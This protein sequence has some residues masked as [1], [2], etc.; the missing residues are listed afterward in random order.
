MDEEVAGGPEEV[1]VWSGWRKTGWTGH[2]A[3]S[4]HAHSHVSCLSLPSRCLLSPPCRHFS[5]LV[6]FRAGLTGSYRD[7]ATVAYGFVPSHP[8]TRFT[9]TGAWVKALNGFLSQQRQEWTQ[10]P[11]WQPDASGGYADAYKYGKRGGDGLMDYV[12]P[13]CLPSVVLGRHLDG[14]GMPKPLPADVEAQLAAC[15]I[16]RVVIGHTPHGNCPTLIKSA[17]GGPSA[18]DVLMADTSYSNM[19][20]AD[21]RGDAVAEVAVLRD[22]STHVHGVLED[23]TTRIDFSLPPTAAAA[24]AAAVSAGGGGGA[25]APS[26]LVGRLTSADGSSDGKIYFVKAFT[27]GKRYLLCNVDGFKVSYLSLS[28][29]ECLEMLGFTPV[30]PSLTSDAPLPLP[31]ESAARS[32]PL[33]V[34]V[35]GGVLGGLAAI[36]LRR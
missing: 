32:M 25:V 13:N 16:R 5:A 27:T 14:K 2:A 33:A 9:D 21:N 29:A 4:R 17:T 3:R 15:G 18:V 10:Q 19:K 7:G 24:S 1:A 30:A 35:A 31:A 20:A 12:V 11:H 23:G 26:R 8:S 36:A 28:P 6:W 34:L 22:G